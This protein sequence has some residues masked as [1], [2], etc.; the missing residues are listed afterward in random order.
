MGRPRDLVRPGPKPA[1]LLRR[2]QL[3]TP[4]T[5]LAWHRRPVR[6]KWRQQPAKSGRPPPAEELT[7][8]ILRLAHDNPTWGYVRVQGELRRLG[9]RVAAATIRRVLRRNKIPP[10]PIRATEH[11]WRAF[12]HTQADTLLATDFF[13]V[14]CAITLKRL[15]VFFVMEV[16]TRTVH[17]LG[18]TTHPTGDWVTQQARNLLLQLGDRALRVPSQAEFWNLT[19]RPTSRSPPRSG[20][21]P[22]GTQDRTF[23]ASPPNFPCSHGLHAPRGDSRVPERESVRAGLRV[24]DTSDVMGSRVR[25][26]SVVFGTGQLAVVLCALWLNRHYHLGSTAALLVAMLPTL[27]GAY[28]GWAAYQDD[29]TEA[30]L[31]LDLKARALAAAVKASERNQVAQLLGAGGQ[32]I[33]VVF[34]YIQQGTGDAE[35]AASRGQLTDVLAYYRRLRPGRLVITGEPGSGKTLLALQLLLTTLDDPEQTDAD[36]VPVRVSLA[37]W[38][39]VRPLTTWLTEQIHQRYGSLGISAADAHTLVNQQR[40]LPVLDGL[41]EMDTATTPAGRH[42]AAAALAK[43]NDYQDVKGSAPLVLT[44]R[45]EQYNDLATVSLWTGRAA[46]VEIQAVEADVAAEYLTARATLD[47]AP[48]RWQPVLDTLNAAPYGTLACA[49]NTP[50][51]LN[52]AVT[53]Y[54]QRDPR[55]LNYVRDPAD[56]LTLP[57]PRAVQ[58]HLLAR[59]IPAAT[60][61]HASP[62]TPAQV[63]RWLGRLAQ[64]LADPTGT[65]P[66]T[67]LVLHQLWPLPGSRRVRTADVLITATLL[68]LATAAALLMYSP[69]DFSSRPVVNVLFPAAIGLALVNEAASGTIRRPSML[70]LHRLS[71][72]AQRRQLLRSTAP[73]LTP[74][75]ASGLAVGLLAGQVLGLVA[76]LTAVLGFGLLIGLVSTLTYTYSDNDPVPPSDP[77]R[78]L[79]DDLVVGLLSMLVAGLV[80]GVITGLMLGLVMGLFLAPTAV[81]RHLAFLCVCRGWILPWRLG[82]FLNWCYDAGLLRISG[83]A[84]QFRHQELQD[85]LIDHPT[86]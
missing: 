57:S 2:H 60:A 7:T 50:W 28:L 67:D 37:G 79:R 51:H 64:H 83:I 74:G 71:T 12:L 58:D 23:D 6:R 38:D 80:F 53:V 76:G 42:R 41:D 65:A 62:Y 75:L 15:Y 34:E 44:C 63:H 39:T 18:V 25:R 86:P 72:R 45:S 22:H 68:A 27:P 66:T 16:G 78:P 49:L 26:V 55:T 14:D 48:D 21:P 19:R 69:S 10:A 1:R 82:A 32:R 4:G 31:D 11:T 81:R 54:T 70:Q 33:D 47:H 35:G 13:H 20:P 8:L 52:L 85:W 59:H 40:V 43:L 36:P 3:L 61:Q 24:R 84:Y 56:L 29:R 77:R 30:A 5:I 9:H 46:R 73:V 17:V